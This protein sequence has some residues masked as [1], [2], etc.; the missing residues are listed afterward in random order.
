MSAVRVSAGLLPFTL[1]ADAPMFFIGHMGGPLWERKDDHAWSLIKGEF[2]PEC[3]APREAAA[4]EWTEETGTPVP[5]GPWIDLDT[6][7]QRNRKVVH[8]FAVEVRDPL[9]VRLESSLSTVRMMWPPRSGRWVTFPEI[10]RAGWNDAEDAKRRLTV[11]QGAFVDRVLALLG[12][13][14]PPA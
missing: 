4:R 6:I 11:G 5:A 8:G 10:D 7:T 13:P 9:E 3:E 12:P 1:A 14:P 2:H